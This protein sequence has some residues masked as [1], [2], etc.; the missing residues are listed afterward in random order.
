LKANR[1][2]R[3]HSNEINREGTSKVGIMRRIE[4]HGDA[5]GSSRFNP[6]WHQRWSP[7]VNPLRI[8]FAAI[9]ARIGLAAD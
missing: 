4:N 5:G 6:L 7:D 8:P 9:A 3:A 2:K 1:F